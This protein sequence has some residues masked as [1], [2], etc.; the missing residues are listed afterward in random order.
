MPRILPW[1]RREGEASRLPSSARSTPVQRV[2]REDAGSAPDE[3]DSAPSPD[4]GD[5]NKKTLKRPRRSGSTSPPPAP[6]PEIFMIEGVENDD[7]HRM[8]ED[9]LLTTAQLFTAHLHAAEY[10]RLKQASELENAQMIK[11]I[12]RP[13]VGRMTD[14][15]KIKRERELLKEKQR[16][17]VRKTRK[18]NS[19]GD[20][21]TGTDDPS[22]SWQK[23]SL[24]GLMESPG[25]RAPRLD[26]LL[27]TAPR[28]RAAAGY[29]RQTIDR[30]GPSRPKLS[31]PSDSDD[32]LESSNTYRPL[33]RTSQ[34]ISRSSSTSF[35]K[36]SE[37]KKPP[38]S[39]SYDDTHNPQVSQIKTEENEAIS[40]DEDLD[41]MARLKKRQA[42]RKQNRE[43]RQSMRNNTKSDSR[44]I[45]PGFL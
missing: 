24:H 36:A 15:V 45:L 1:K 31:V 17:A 28:T 7:R 32:D 30:A 43:Q 16:L 12:S 6:P 14:M 2:A 19:G 21:S 33:H 34:P 4:A 5:Q 35:P 11:S 9:E 27:T 3:V 37:F 10:K 13:V 42:E 44:D 20:E 18:G 38:P 25:K 8:V 39:S 26:G 23:L 41:F 22:D 29:S 40:D